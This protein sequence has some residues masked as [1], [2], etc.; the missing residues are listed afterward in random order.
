MIVSVLHFVAKNSGRLLVSDEIGT[1]RDQ[2]SLF[3][4]NPTQNGYTLNWDVQRTVWEH[5][6]Y[7][8]LMIDCGE[9]CAVVT[10][11]ELDPL[12]NQKAMDE[13]FFEDYG[14]KS[15]CRVNPSN[16][17]ADRYREIS[18][19]DGCIIVESGHSF[20]HIVPYWKG[21]KLRKGIVRLDI[22]GKLLTN[23]LKETLSYRQLNLMDE[24]KVCEEIKEAACFCSDDYQADMSRCDKLA[25]IFV[26]PDYTLGFKGRLENVGAGFKQSEQ[27][28]RLARERFQVPEVMF[29]PTDAQIHHCGIHEAVHQSVLKCPAEYQP[30]LYR[31]IMMMG[32]NTGF[33]N[34]RARLLDG[35]RGLADDEYDVRVGESQMPTTY[36]WMCAAK[37][38]QN[39]NFPAERCVTKADWAEYGHRATETKF[40]QI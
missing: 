7:D 33:K 36:A 24:F 21:V 18:K 3:Y 26:L 4:L 39:V 25:K 35:I 37:M 14:F 8:R 5:I 23:L 9:M 16:I 31:N 2:S 12:S 22:G 11:P 32:G 10:E 34:F 1:H 13:V 15:L 40:N 6:F 30:I 28:I 19:T 29:N 27:A 17:V 38:A 20:T